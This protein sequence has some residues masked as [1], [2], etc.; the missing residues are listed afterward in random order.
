MLLEYPD[1]FHFDLIVHDFSMGP[2]LLGFVH[3][4]KNPPLVAV[5]AY[6]HP[7]YLTAIIRGHQY[8]SYVPHMY[9][10]A[11]EDDMNIFQ[12]MYNFAVHVAE[13]L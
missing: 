6:G 8:Y 9:N 5:T 1:D 7:A 10:S 4:F 2:C 11:Y 3:K 12:R 13:L